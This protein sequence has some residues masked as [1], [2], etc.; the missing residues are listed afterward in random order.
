MINRIKKDKN[1]S[2]ANDVEFGK[3]ERN[4]KSKEGYHFVG[5]LDN[6]TS[7]NEQ[8]NRVNEIEK[9]TKKKQ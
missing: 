7:I 5:S 3:N 2:I 4:D 6:W 8:K 1:I 9:V